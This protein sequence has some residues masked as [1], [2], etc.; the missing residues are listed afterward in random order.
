ME[1]CSK[2][3]YVHVYFTEIVFNPIIISTSVFWQDAF[4][5]F[6]PQSA[7]KIDDRKYCEFWMFRSRTVVK[8]AG[9]V[10]ASR[11]AVEF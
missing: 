9:V 4:Y 3:V 10:N 8:E 7:K 6:R 2:D 1:N 5:A 11:Y